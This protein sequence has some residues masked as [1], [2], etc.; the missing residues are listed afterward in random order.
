MSIGELIM[1]IQIGT[2]IISK[3]G[4]SATVKDIIVNDFTDGEF[5]VINWQDDKDTIFST[6]FDYAKR[7]IAQGHWK[8]DKTNRQTDRIF[9]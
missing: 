5:I 7:L 3:K 6:S 8:I 2:A 4:K 1:K 9:S